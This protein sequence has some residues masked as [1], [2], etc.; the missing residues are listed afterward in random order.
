MSSNE[1]REHVKYLTDAPKVAAYRAAL[2]QVMPSDGVVVDLGCGTGLLGL[3]ACQLG[4]RKVYAIDAGAIISVAREVAAAAG[5][6]DRIEHIQAMSVDV[7]LPESVDVVV[8]DQIGGMAYEAGVL[9][10]YDDARRFLKPGGVMVPESFEVRLAPVE[11]EREW[12][13]AGAWKREETGFGPSFAPV[14][15]HAVNTVFS[16]HCTRDELLGPTAELAC[17]SSSANTPF[18]GRVELPVTRPGMLHGLL[19]TFIA[20]MAPGV[21][22]TNDPAA[23]EQMAHRWQTLLPLAEPVAVSV[24]DRV[25]AT[26]AVWPASY[27]A[28][29]KVAVVGVDG[30]KRNESHSTFEGQFLS[31]D[32]IAASSTTTEI[33]TGRLDDAGFALGLVREGASIDSMVGALIADG[34]FPSPAGAKRFATKV[35]RLLGS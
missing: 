12:R 23:A 19:G 27:F 13:V 6:A 16:V 31:L 34:R 25:E 24:G 10:F 2:A 7:T 4:A 15:R 22:M 20:R 29:W 30:V 26:V 3:I 5:Y 35:A 33:P 18:D 14:G 17:M 28:S 9:E 8:A 32:S 1:L 21:T 11:S